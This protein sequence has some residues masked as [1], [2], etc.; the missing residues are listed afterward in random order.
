MVYRE[1][2]AQPQAESDFSQFLEGLYTALTD[3]RRDP[4][5]VVRDTLYQ[6]YFGAQARARS[7]CAEVRSRK[8]FT[9][10]QSRRA[11]FRSPQYHNRAGIL[12]RD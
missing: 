1:L 12:F 8:S 5:E 7:N 9:G 6:I 10:R 3:G 11:L 2:A 4:N